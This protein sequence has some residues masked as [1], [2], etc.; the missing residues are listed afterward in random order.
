MGTC[1]Q[2]TAELVA[3]SAA[4]FAGRYPH[5]HGYNNLSAAR[6]ESALPAAIPTHHIIA[7]LGSMGAGSSS[8][9]LN[10]RELQ[11]AEREPTLL[12]DRI[13]NFILTGIRD[14][15]IFKMQDAT[16]C[17]QYL[18]VSVEQLKT[19]FTELQLYPMQ[20]AGGKI[21][22]RKISDL[23]KPA[24]QAAK[25][26]LGAN[27][28]AIGYFYVR[29]VQIYL[30]LALTILD[31]PVI[32]AMG[33]GAPPGFQRGGATPPH[34]LN[35]IGGG[36]EFTFK[37]MTNIEDS[38]HAFI[39]L[40]DRGQP[41]VYSIPRRDAS[42][43]S[44]R[45]RTSSDGSGKIYG[46]K[47]DPFTNTERKT[48]SE[49]IIKF[50]QGQG[51][52]LNKIRIIAA[53][54]P[55][56]RPAYYGAIDEPQTVSLNIDVPI[57]DEYKLAVP[58]GKAFRGGY[59][60]A[61]ST[62]LRKLLDE[63]E[64]GDIKTIRAYAQQISSRRESEFSDI[65][66]VYDRRQPTYGLDR[67]AAAAAQP[68]LRS[69]SGQAAL[70]FSSALQALQTTRPLAHCVARSYQLLA[71]DTMAGA[72]EARTHICNKSFMQRVQVPDGR[73]ITSIEGV[74]ALNF[75]FQVLDRT[76]IGLSARSEDGLRIALQLFSQTFSDGSRPVPTSMDKIVARV[77]ARCG[78]RSSSATLVG[79]PD[80]LTA[81]AGVDALWAYQRKHLVVVA[82]MFKLLFNVS[83]DGAVVG[84]NPRILAGGIPYVE[85]LAEKAR[86]VLVDY[87][88]NCETIYQV[89]VGKFGSVRIDLG[90]QR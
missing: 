89:T 76:K 16:T 9:L 84:F 81:K 24:E 31:D 28:L 72:K 87:Y 36:R 59:A 5:V 14:K 69:G 19:L 46:S 58:Y 71:M 88:T 30:A 82:N 38:E 74:K 75:L 32:G 79:K 68:A 13:L 54:I 70:N 48:K 85:E 61:I 67:Q 34:P 45:L 1:C 40:S 47:K 90:P 6:A 12:M 62:F 18:M 53:K 37:S 56:A 80:I 26:Q 66:D 25:E 41:G 42:Q 64:L 3:Q 10:K 4:G 2:R 11:A 83:R 23:T 33:V 86:I 43:A 7:L 15:D 50:I 52:R 49:Y 22:F 51:D 39:D 57:T 21:L 77:P 60:T 17:Q 8:L 78:S 29:I 63:F 65:A 35:L 20:G 55:A 27:C 44:V 73:A